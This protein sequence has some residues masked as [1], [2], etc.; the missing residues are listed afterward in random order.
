MISISPTQ[1]V[2]RL[3]PRMDPLMMLRPIQ[4]SDLMPA[5]MPSG[6]PKNIAMSIA[7][8]ASSSVAG[9]RCK[10]S[11]KAGSLKTKELPRLPRRAL[12]KKIQYCSHMGLSSPRALTASSYSWG[13]ASG[14]IKMSTGLPMAYTPT[15]TSRD[16]ASNTT[17]L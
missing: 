7:P 13:V 1:N 11:F 14:L 5:I 4:L 9:R 12:V 8:Q 17:L 3:K 16:M 6:M 15:N 10:I 2:G